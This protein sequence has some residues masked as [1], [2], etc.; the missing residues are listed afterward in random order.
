MSL[1]APF[2]P[3]FQAVFHDFYVDSGI[4]VFVPVVYKRN[5]RSAGDDT[6]VRPA[7]EK[8]VRLL[9]CARTCH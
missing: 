4:S 2:L 7:Q 1:F 5:F 3:Y 9:Y 6:V 8:L